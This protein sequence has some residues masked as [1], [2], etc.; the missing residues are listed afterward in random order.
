MDGLND[1]VGLGKLGMIIT[2]YLALATRP[3]FKLV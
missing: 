3:V 2:S 1:F